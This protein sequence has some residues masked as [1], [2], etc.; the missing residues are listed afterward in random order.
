MGGYHAGYSTKVVHKVDLNEL[1]HKGCI[2]AG[3]THPLADDKRHSTQTT[4]LLSIV[5]GSLLAVGG[6]DDQ[7]TTQAHPST[8]I[9]LTPGG[10]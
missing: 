2:Q 1:H 4:L 9:S 8:S 10:G 7:Y 3:H 5:R 6:C